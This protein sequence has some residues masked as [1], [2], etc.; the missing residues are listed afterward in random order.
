[1]SY[2]FL[3]E[4]IDKYELK[5]VQNTIVNIYIRYIYIGAF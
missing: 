1:M 4:F 2:L 5:P 3:G